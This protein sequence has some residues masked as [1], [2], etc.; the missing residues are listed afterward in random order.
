MKKPVRQSPVVFDKK[1][2]QTEMRGDWLVVTAYEN[3]GAGPF[4]IDL[5]HL[6]RWDV[7]H[8]DLDG[9]KPCGLDIPTDPGAVCWSSDLLV[10][11]MNRTQASLWH[12]SGRTRVEPE[13]PTCTDTTDATAF[14]ALLGNKVFAIAEKVSA[15]DFLS[16]EKQEPCL[17][18][19]PVQ[20]VPC[21][22]VVMDR[23]PDDGCLLMT[24]SR[25]YARDMVRGLLQA[26]REFDLTPA[27][28]AAFDEWMQRRNRRQ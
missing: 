11:R 19:G 21:Q 8:E 25:G 24:F 9:L 6:E 15:L 1:A 18:Q 28:E 10:N 17:F 12:L 20:H 22:V 5:S 2:A 14:I 3:E 16:P 26:G 27:G 4:V 23:S 7:Q 13:Y